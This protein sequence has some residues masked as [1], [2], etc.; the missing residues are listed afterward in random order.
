MSCC[1]IGT[2]VDS[3]GVVHSGNDES[4]ESL[5]SLIEIVSAEGYQLVNINRDS[6]SVITTA[7]VIWPDG[8]SGTFTTLVKNTTWLTIDSFSITY[9]GAPVKTITQ[10]AVTRDINGAVTTKP[11]LTII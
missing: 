1:A 10:P 11:L 9:N 3:S 2:F 6:D 4:L 5:Q 8:K 7:S